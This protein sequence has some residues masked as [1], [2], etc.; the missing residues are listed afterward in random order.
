VGNCLQVASYPIKPSPKATH[1]HLLWFGH[2]L[3]YWQTSCAKDDTKLKKKK[4]LAESVSQQS[5]QSKGVLRYHSSN[6]VLPLLCGRS[7]LKWMTSSATQWTAQVSCEWGLQAWCPPVVSNCMCSG[8]SPFIP[9]GGKF[10]QLQ[11]ICQTRMQ[12]QAVQCCMHWSFSNFCAL[13]CRAVSGTEVDKPQ[14]LLM[15]SVII[16]V[17]MRRMDCEDCHIYTSLTQYSNNADNILGL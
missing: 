7:P 17:V 14:K 8:R 4:S 16:V 13:I 10:A 1:F 12:C 2:F 3:F 9:M 5:L 6:I 11:L 15:C